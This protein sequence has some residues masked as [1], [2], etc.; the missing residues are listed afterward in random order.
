MPY[1]FTSE[2]VSEGHPDKVADQISDALID[3]FLA[4]ANHC[5]VKYGSI[6]ELDL[7]P[8]GTLFF[9]FSF[10]EKKEDKDFHH[11]YVYVFLLF[12]S[13]KFSRLKNV[14]IRFTRS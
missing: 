14:N 13:S 7:L 2:S 9:I 11:H 8:Y 1:F 3:N 12:F 6:I 10:E 5:S 4:S